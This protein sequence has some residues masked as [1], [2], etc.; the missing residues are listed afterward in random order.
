MFKSLIKNKYFQI[1]VAVG[2]LASCLKNKAIIIKSNKAEQHPGEINRVNSM[3]QT[4]LN[5]NITAITDVIVSTNNAKTEQIMEGF[6]ATFLALVY[7]G[8]L[9]DTLTPSQ[10]SQALDAIFNQ[11]KISMG[12][13]PVS[14]EAPANSDL[15]SFFTNQA[16]DNSDP[17]NLNWNGFS[18]AWGNMFK[19][20]VVDIAGSMFNLYPD[21]RINITANSKWLSP[22]Q[23]SNYNLFLDESAEQVL[24][25]V[26]FWKHTYGNE[27]AY[28]MLF[29]EPLSGN[30]ELGLATAQTVTDIVKKSGD[31]LRQAGFNRVKF[32]VPSEET[33]F[34]SLDTAKAVLADH[35]A[36]QYVGAIGYHPYP[37][38]G[39]YSWPPSILDTSG[40]GHPDQ[41]RVSVRYQLRDLA[42][43][44]GVKLF[45]TE[46]SSGPASQSKPIN[47]LSYEVFRAR[48]IHIHDELTYAN[49]SAFFG[50]NSMWDAVS[51]KD[52]FRGRGYEDDIFADEGDIVRIDNATDKVYIT[53]M[54][55]AVGHYA[56]G[57]NKGAVRIETASSDRLVQVTAFRDDAHKQMVW[58]IINNNTSKKTVKFDVNGLT[59]TGYL[60]GEQST[61]KAYWQK[62]NALTPDT[63]SSFTITLPEESV[64]TITSH[65]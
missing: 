8:S 3:N 4:I 11:V 29:N 16:N 25:G 2:L 57:I 53:G 58:V 36:W 12:Q 23:N 56:R 55:R 44:Y 18:T 31:R 64:T 20:K 37:Y 34:K 28:A 63:S 47:P 27:P 30:M 54:G 21:V 42:E 51:Q 10:R 40:K 48:A 35:G 26:T 62:L 6:G 45:M 7:G 1:I 15:S 52:H 5:L 50:M 22:I 9:G 46:V 17:F 41:S 60:S 24:A 19:Q 14:F 49:A 32:I 65:Y 61:A 59:L 38:L 13:I 33:E 39:I 43:K